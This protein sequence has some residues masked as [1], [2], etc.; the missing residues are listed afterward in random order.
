[1]GTVPVRRVCGKPS[2]RRWRAASGA[3]LPFQGGSR[4]RRADSGAAGR[5][6]GERV[7]LDLTVTG[8]DLGRNGEGVW[9]RRDARAGSLPRLPGSRAGRASFGLHVAGRGAGASCPIKWQIEL[10]LALAPCSSCSMLAPN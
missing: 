10:A 3:G 7:P 5:L 2:G 1:M 8:G 9:E 4:S 6:N